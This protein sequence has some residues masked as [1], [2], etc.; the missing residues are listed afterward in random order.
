ME[1]MEPA[2]DCLYLG[3]RAVEGREPVPPEACVCL[4]SEKNCLLNCLSFSAAVSAALLAASKFVCARLN[5]FWVLFFGAPFPH[6]AL[7]VG[8]GLCF[9]Y[10]PASGVGVGSG[11]LFLLPPPAVGFAFV[12]YPRKL[13]AW[14]YFGR[15]SLEPDGFEALCLFLAEYGREGLLALVRGVYCCCCC[16]C[17][18]CCCG[19]GLCKGLFS[20]VGGQG[21]C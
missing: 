18:A 2:E 4:Y 10:L 12:L 21:S 17:F 15:S 7:G 11:L 8:I 6:S 3:S 9:V 20:V 14:A 19:A 13:W 1:G 5:S 16:C